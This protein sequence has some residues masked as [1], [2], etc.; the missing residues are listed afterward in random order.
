MLKVLFPITM[1]LSTLWRVLRDA[2]VPVD[3]VVVCVQPDG[4]VRPV[5]WTPRAGMAVSAEIAS[6]LP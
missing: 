6:A 5:S 3:E 4:S 2:G 1:A